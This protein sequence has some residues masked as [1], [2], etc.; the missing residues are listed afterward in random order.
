[1]KK[2]MFLS[3]LFLQIIAAKKAD[4]IKISSINPHIKIDLIWATGNNPLGL[5]LYPDGIEC[6]LHKPAAL[7]L[8]EVQKELETMGYGLKVLEAFRPLWAQK[9]VW[10]FI[11]YTPLDPNQGRHT[12]G[13]A[14]DVTIIDL[15]SE[16][17][18]DLP[19]YIYDDNREY[20]ETIITEIQKKNCLLLKTLM[21]KHN[22]IPMDEEWF[23]FDYY[24]WNEYEA[25]S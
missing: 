11:K 6:Y 16:E 2:F 13:L 7:A 10:D 8:S 5:I 24:N 23:H 14:V 3:V 15:K 19:P 1:M 25:L 22:F 9:M 18:I 12:L 20:P 17:E 21:M 4:L